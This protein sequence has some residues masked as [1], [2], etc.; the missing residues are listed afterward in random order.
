MPKPSSVARE[1]AEQE[2][3]QLVCKWEHEDYAIGDPKSQRLAADL[4][5]LVERAILAAVEQARAE[6]REAL[7]RYVEWLRRD[8]IEALERG[9]E[10]LNTRDLIGATNTWT[11]AIRA[12]GSDAEAKGGRDAKG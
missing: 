5:L 6:E 12:Q 8:L 1:I 10:R 2:I 7:C 4:R 9:G 3:V 11:A